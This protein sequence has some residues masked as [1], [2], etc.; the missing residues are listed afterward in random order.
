MH[1][2]S[3]N[4]HVTYGNATQ[5]HD[6][7]HHNT[8]TQHTTARH[9]NTPNKDVIHGNATHGNATYGNAPNKHT[10]M[11]NE[12]PRNHTPPRRVTTSHTNEYHT[13]TPITHP[14]TPEQGD[15]YKPRT[16]RAEYGSSTPHLLAAGVGYYKVI[17]F[18]T[19]M[20]YS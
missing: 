5:Q 14:L 8:E 15:L 2:E 1:D 13:R 18:F 19:D 12:A 16:M 9:G 3:P 10:T 6:I 17:F 4:S 7:W 20:H 11:P